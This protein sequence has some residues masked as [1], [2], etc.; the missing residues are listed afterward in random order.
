MDAEG[1]DMESAPAQVGNADMGLATLWWQAPAAW[2]MGWIAI[3]LLLIAVPNAQYG[4]MKYAKLQ[5]RPGRHQLRLSPRVSLE[6]HVSPGSRRW[7]VL[8]CK[9]GPAG[10]GLEPVLTKLSLELPAVRLGGIAG[11]LQGLRLR[12]VSL[13]RRLGALTPPGR[14]RTWR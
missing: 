13:A 10:E 4:N 8:D 11:A 6:L 3:L 2:G 12:L 7:C 1:A 5:L 9:A 14:A